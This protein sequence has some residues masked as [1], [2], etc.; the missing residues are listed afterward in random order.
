MS[1]TKSRDASFY[2]AYIQELYI[3][4]IDNDRF[5]FKNVD[6]ANAAFKALIPAIPVDWIYSQMEGV[7]HK[8]SDKRPSVKLERK[9][10]LT[11]PDIDT[12][13]LDGRIYKFQCDHNIIK[14]GGV[15]GISKCYETEHVHRCDYEAPEGWFIF[16]PEDGYKSFEEYDL[17]HENPTLHVC[18]PRCAKRIADDLETDIEHLSHEEVWDARQFELDFIE[19]RKESE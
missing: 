4:E 16:N 14:E 2:D 17:E 11:E 10:I 18:C 1:M 7:S 8:L 15:C 13:A 6:D 5:G 19:K 9:R 12:L 3:V